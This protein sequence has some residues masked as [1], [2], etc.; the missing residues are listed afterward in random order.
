MVNPKHISVKTFDYN[1]PEDR[2]ARYPLPNRDESR[3]LIYNSGTITI[4]RFR[5]VPRYLSS[6]QLLV[7]NNAKVVYAR[8]IFKK[9]TGAPVEIFCLEPLKPPDY[10]SA[11][12]QSSTVRW[13]CMVGNLKK[14]K[15]GE[16]EQKITINEKE[17]R[18]KARKIERVNNQVII[19]F[20]WD[21]ETVTF[22]DILDHAGKVPIPP[23]LKRESEKID[24]ERYQTVYSKIKGSVA[25]PTAGFHFS[26]RV[27]KEMDKK[28]IIRTELTL[29]VGAGTFRPVT[30]ETAG[31]HTMH[32]EHFS[33]SRETLDQLIEQYD[34]IIAVGTTSV[35][36]LESLYWIGIK[37]NEQYLGDASICLNQWEHLQLPDKMGVTGALNVIKQYLE[38]TG[39]NHLNA[40][41]QIMIT[42]GYQFRLT[43]GL[44]TNFHLPKSTLL[45]LIAAFVGEDWKKIYDCALRNDFRFLSYGDSSLLLP[46]D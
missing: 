21:D 33:I 39:Q 19:K 10:A 4:D 20:S 5:N 18:L 30:T 12:Q 25:A 26:D 29:H 2:I 17:I 37:I 6:G 22:G 46:F 8:L 40:S 43:R 41:T 27:I 44:I 1:L 45:M 11:F 9:E 42:P 7:F 15:T 23:Y 14:W 3:L 28:G 38:N 35:R 13:K 31:Q 36:T 34:N 16:L 24:K 32:L